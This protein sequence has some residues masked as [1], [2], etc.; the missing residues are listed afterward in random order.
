MLFRSPDW[1]A[2]ASL[3]RRIAENYKLPYYTMSPTYSVCA[4]HGY[5]AGEVYTCPICGKPTEVYSRITGYYRPVQNWNVGKSEEFK[6]RKTYNI[7][8]SKLK[9]ENEG[10]A[11]C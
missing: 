10:V 5:L 4:N 6:E 3:V 1:R 2:A 8:S 7:I 9:H 11:S